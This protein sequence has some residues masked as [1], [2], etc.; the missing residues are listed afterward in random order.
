MEKTGNAI[1]STCSWFHRASS[2]VCTVLHLIPSSEGLLV[3][4]WCTNKMEI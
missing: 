2:G 1:A 3:Q 4:T